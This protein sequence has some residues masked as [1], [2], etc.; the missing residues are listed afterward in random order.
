MYKN[1]LME[2]QM[3]L[4]KDDLFILQHD[5]DVMN[6]FMAYERL[7]DDINQYVLLGKRNR[8]TASMLLAQY[9]DGGYV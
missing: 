4:D 7:I 2:L 9:I 1:E 3:C 5:K 6:R 8:Q